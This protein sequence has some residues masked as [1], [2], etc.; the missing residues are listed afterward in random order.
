MT[1]PNPNGWPY[2]D[3]P[4]VPLHPEQ[5]TSGHILLVDGELD[6]YRWVAANQFFVDGRGLWVTPHELTQGVDKYLGRMHTPAEVASLVEAARREAFE[7]SI[8]LVQGCEHRLGSGATELLQVLRQHAD[9][10][11]P[12]ARGEGGGA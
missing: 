1:T 5:D 10:H 12:R 3:R 9:M 6:V 8:R 11:K 7:Q 2:P 4:G